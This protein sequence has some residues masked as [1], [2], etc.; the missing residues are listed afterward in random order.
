MKI[1]FAPSLMC[2]DLMRVQEQVSILNQRCD[3]Y[4]VDIMDGHFVKNLS[5]SVD[6]VKGLRQITNLPIDC[7]LMVTN[8]EQYI[9]PLIKAGA[10]SISLHAET[11]SGQA[12]R[13]FNKIRQADCKCGVVLNPETSLETVKPYL[14]Y[15]DLLTFMTV[16]PGFAGQDFIAETMKSINEAARWKERNAY[17]YI[18]AV[19]GACNKNTFSRL[20]DAGTECFIVGSSGLFNL[21]EDL[22][23]A[24]DT[25]MQDFRQ[26][27]STDK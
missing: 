8:P 20:A 16:D 13:L 21:H 2:M 27:L 12:F 17:S 5:L 11:I 25:M 4:H 15:L 1:K 24:Y 14:N 9:D 3:L 7:H 23:I 26:S 19:D 10:D 6:F 22:N 18:L